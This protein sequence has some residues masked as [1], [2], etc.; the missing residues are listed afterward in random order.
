MII[1][2]SM[3]I[4]SITIKAYLHIRFNC[5]HKNNVHDS[6]I[7]IMLKYSR[8]LK[9]MSPTHS[10]TYIHTHTARYSLNNIKGKIQIN[11]NNDRLRLV[12]LQ[13][14]IHCQVE[15]RESSTVN[16]VYCK[17]DVIAVIILWSEESTIWLPWI[18]SVCCLRVTSLW[19][20]EHTNISNDT[21]SR[22][23]LSLSLYIYIYI[24]V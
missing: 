7:E 8:T 9:Y 12:N 2:S 21:L 13:H 4:W 19:K 5:R 24:Y 17:N 23:S 18:T 16:C 11:I 20:P 3:V 22:K 15:E 6:N 10:H 14:W 1:K